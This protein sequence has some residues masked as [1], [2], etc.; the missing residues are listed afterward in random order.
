MNCRAAY[1]GA[2]A[3]KTRNHGIGF[4]VAR[5]MPVA[6]ARKFVGVPPYRLVIDLRDGG[7]FDVYNNE[8]YDTIDDAKD[9]LARSKFVGRITNI[10]IIDSNG[11]Q[12]E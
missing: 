6:I 7:T 11:D 12:V 8:T 10:R 2:S 5:A 9:R 4:R 3:P 1:R